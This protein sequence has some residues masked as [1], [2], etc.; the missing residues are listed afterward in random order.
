MRIC[1]GQNHWRKKWEG[2]GCLRSLIHLNDEAELPSPP[3]KNGRS[4]TKV[5]SYLHWFESSLIDFGPV[6]SV[7]RP[8]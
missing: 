1:C 2:D 3:S 5:A 6:V 7:A 8:Q 4:I